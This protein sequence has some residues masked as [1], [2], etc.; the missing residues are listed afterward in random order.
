MAPIAKKCSP[1]SN[2]PH[3][4]DP[5]ELC[6]R[7]YF[8][9]ELIHIAEAEL[10]SRTLDTAVKG[11]KFAKTRPRQILHGSEIQFEPS[12]S[13]LLSEA[14]ELWPARFNHPSIE[15][16]RGESYDRSIGLVTDDERTVG[17]KHGVV[18][19]TR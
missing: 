2:G 17:A 15:F 12:A 19:A 6:D 18:Q 1:S 4:Q 13:T 3:I 9:G 7:K 16:A 8:D 11:D 5:V 10:P 14:V